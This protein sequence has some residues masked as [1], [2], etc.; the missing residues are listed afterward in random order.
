MT[1]GEGPSVRAVT[2]L[3]YGASMLQCVNVCVCLDH[4]LWRVC[5]GACCE[6]VALQCVNVAVCQGV[7][8]P[9]PSSME[10]VLRCVLQ[11]VASVLEFVT[12]VSTCV[13]GSIIIYI[14]GRSMIY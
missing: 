9:R 10:R 3:K 7:C 4:D 13:I 1:Y 14:K 6:C 8:L 5:F 2:V 11:F 12:S